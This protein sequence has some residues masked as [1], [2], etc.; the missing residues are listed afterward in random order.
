MRVYKNKINLNKDDLEIFFKGRGNRLK[1]DPLTAVLYQDNNPKLAHQRDQFEK[2]KILPLLK[3]TRDD[4]V[5][6]IA[7]GI[8]RW[9]DV[10]HEQVELYTGIDFQSEFI[11]YAR[12]KYKEYS[13]IS[14]LVL[15][16]TM[17]SPDTLGR[18]DY[19]KVL[20]G[21]LLLYLNDN[22]IAHLFE[23]LVDVTSVDALVYLREP[24]AIDDRLSL[25][26]NWSEDLNQNYSA[27]YRTREEI[28]SLIKG[29]VVSK[30]DN[31]Y[32][33]NLNNRKETKQYYFLL[34]KL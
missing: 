32:E 26:K 4:K 7:C 3:L 25:K 2:E 9:V 30:E 33:N 24:I 18:S 11:H 12:N 29:F 10:L 6:D 34:K 14:F 20:I 27:V 28:L 1:K 19:T 15:D 21:G 13:N 8:G 31:M 22:Q 17:I 23:S 5:L 16:A